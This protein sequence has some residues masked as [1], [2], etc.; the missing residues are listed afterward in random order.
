MSRRTYEA[1][2]EHIETAEDLGDLVY[3]KRESW[4]A[5][6]G[7]VRRRLRRYKKSFTHE[8][9]RMHH[10]DDDHRNLMEDRSNASR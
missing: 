10:S 8:L 6:S 4:R 7:K 9:L 2:A 1:D 5:N 3:D